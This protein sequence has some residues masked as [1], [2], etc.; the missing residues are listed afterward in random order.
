M[1]PV[2]ELERDYEYVQGADPL[3][4]AQNGRVGVGDP[5][6]HFTGDVIGTPK[7]KLLAAQSLDIVAVADHDRL[8]GPTIER[9]RDNLELSLEIIS[10][11]EITADSLGSDRGQHS[12][13]HLLV[14]RLKK[15][16]P[17]K[18]TSGRLIS[19][20]DLIKAAHDQG[21]VVAVAHPELG[22]F[23]Y[24]ADEIR[25]MAGWDE[26]PDLI[27]VFNGGARNVDRSRLGRVLRE[28][29]SGL[30]KR[31]PASGSNTQARTI[32]EEVKDKLFP[33]G[34]SDAHNARNVRD[35]VT[36]FDPEM[37]FF[38]AIRAGR[39]FVMRRKKPNRHTI[40]NIVVGTIKG[41]QLE[42]SR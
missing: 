9:K 13:K 27:E 12:G 7:S 37:D 42:K 39:S 18:T 29:V 4:V 24:I 34:G 1:T 28:H 33:L 23:S 11:S 10:A 38:A 20:Q 5:H 35:V 3:T 30:E 16:I 8:S 19:P 36:G 15:L 40:S 14:Y 41:R 6:V 22:G 2:A 25:E 32:F 21:A 26:P 17:C 31:I